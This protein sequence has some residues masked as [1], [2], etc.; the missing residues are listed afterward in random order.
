MPKQ[1]NWSATTMPP[2]KTD[3]ATSSQGGGGDTVF[4]DARGLRA[5]PNMACNSRSCV[6][7]ANSG[8]LTRKRSKNPNH[9]TYVNSVAIM[10]KLTTTS[11]KLK[12]GRDLGLL[13]RFADNIIPA[14]CVIK[15]LVRAGR[16]DHNTPRRRRHRAI[17]CAPWI[18]RYRF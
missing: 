9:C 2:A 15:Y 17:G 3:R 14:L 6:I 11:I 16:D 12:A 8:A 1:S 10:T 4:T 18:H 5:W 13:D 7:W